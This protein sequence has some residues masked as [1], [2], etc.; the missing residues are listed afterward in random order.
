M[1]RNLA[2][3][4]LAGV[5]LGGC[6]GVGEEETPQQITEIEEL[7]NRIEV[8]ERIRATQQRRIEELAA[9]VERLAKEKRELEEALGI[10]KAG[11]AAEG[12]E[13]AG[14][15][16]DVVEI[17][18]MLPTTAMDWDG[19]GGDDGISVF[20]A[21]ID[22]EGDA[23]KRAGSFSFEFYDGD[24][25]GGEP[26]MRWALEK[27]DVTRRWVLFP[28]SYHFRLMWPGEKKPPEKGL[29]VGRFKSVL[30]REFSARKKIDIKMEE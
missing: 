24:V 18:F 12:K 9:E 25:E 30:G 19:K 5:L 20:I 3:V 27:E 13:K 8:L 2:Q 7:N 10:E 14:L 21:P 15:D 29:L 4:V 17:R 1:R 23:I 28:V 26:V 16:F 22:E 11:A 6:V